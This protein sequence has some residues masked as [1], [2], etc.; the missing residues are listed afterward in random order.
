MIDDLYQFTQDLFLFEEFSRIANSNSIFKTRDARAIYNKVITK[1]SSNFNFL[2]T[3]NILSLLVTN[4]KK[5]ILERQEFFSKLGQTKN[6]FL[7]DL[8]LDVSNRFRVSYSVAIATEDEELYFRYKKQKLN[9]YLIENPNDITS[10]QDYDLVYA[11]DVDQFSSLLENLSQVMFVNEEQVF[12]ERYLTTLSVWKNIILK[13]NENKELFSMCGIDINNENLVNNLI[14]CLP[15]LEK[16]EQD[17][18]NIDEINQNLYD[19]NLELSEK[20]SQMTLKGDI[21]FQIANGKSVPQVESII[22]EIIIKCDLPQSIIERG[23]PLKLNQDEVKSLLLNQKRDVY[24]NFV[25]KLIKKSDVII[26]IPHLIRELERKIILF[27]F[28]SSVSNLK[29]D[30]KIKFG[31]D[32]RLSKSS[33]LFIDNAHPIDFH[34]DDKHRCSILTG[35]NSGGKTTLLEH[36]IQIISL[37]SMGL[38]VNGEIESCLFSEVYYFAKNKGVAGSGAFE[39]LLNQLSKIDV[40][41]NT[42]ILA[43]EIEA[44][45]E[46]GVAAKIISATCSY[47]T[48]KGC[49]MIVATHLGFEIVNN[50]PDFSRVDGIE[51]KGLDSNMNLIVEHNPVLGRLA[52][53]T[54]QLIVEKLA[55]TKGHDYFTY[56]YDSLST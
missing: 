14:D 31:S 36:V 34:L 49:K 2:A 21:L 32:F 54:P 40:G 7:K 33:N 39:K 16:K 1:I 43:D 22:D 19:A 4:N 24:L 35:A 10:L 25:N 38:L 27:D 15:L 12:L 55:N 47:F 45:T 5:M 56:V 6:D 13:A 41:K 30:S 51:A 17:G 46:P 3:K 8:K 18:F 48:N 11:I 20:L 9:V 50:M 52:H 28:L 53:S 26:K 37:T 23:I 44:V 42:L 29:V